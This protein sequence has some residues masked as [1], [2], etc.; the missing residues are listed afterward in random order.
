MGPGGGVIVRLPGG[1]VSFRPNGG[2][3]SYGASATESEG[4]ERKRG[5]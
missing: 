1:G 2:T 5:G 4:A 3:A